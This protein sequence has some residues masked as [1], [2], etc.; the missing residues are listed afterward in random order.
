MLITY[1]NN[2]QISQG[3]Q[4]QR[5]HHNNLQ[6]HN[7]ANTL[8][9]NHSTPSLHRAASDGER[10]RGYNQGNQTNTIPAHYTN[11]NK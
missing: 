10:I 6:Y 8:L 11:G 3:N 1:G 7:G 9:M 2:N 4:N 5:D